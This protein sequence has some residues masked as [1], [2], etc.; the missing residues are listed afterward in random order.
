MRPARLVEKGKLVIR[1][2]LSEVE[3]LE[4]PGVGTL[5]AFNTDGLRTLLKLKIP[6]MQ[7]KT[8]R[9]PGHAE[10]MRMLRHTGFF[11]TTPMRVGKEVTTARAPEPVTHGRVRLGPDG[12]VQRGHAG[13]PVGELE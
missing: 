2:A 8:L 11:D 10:R 12:A 9:Y 5:E 4:I 13:P 7:E 1:Q 6:N 3:L